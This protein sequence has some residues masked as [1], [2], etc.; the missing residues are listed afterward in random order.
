MAGRGLAACLDALAPAEAEVWGRTG[1]NLESAYERITADDGGHRRIQIPMLGRV[2]LRMGVVERAYLIA[3]DELRDLPPG[4]ALDTTRGVFTWAPGLGYLGTY[5]LVFVRGDERL[6]FDV[7]IRPKE[8]A[9]PDAGSIPMAVDTPRS[10]ETVH[11]TISITGWAI[12]PLA[13]HGSGV[14]AVHV[15]A[16]RLDVPESSPQFL[17]AAALGGARPDVAQVYGAMFSHPGFSLTASSLAPGQ[18]NI[19]VYVRTDANRWV[20][21]QTVEVSV[22]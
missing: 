8:S 17:G 20:G 14:N 2:E 5:R 6:V 22:R 18:Y 13:W 3:G 19:T 15:W 12:D 21:A 11:G 16:E 4:S 9:A 7:T 1:F 10:A